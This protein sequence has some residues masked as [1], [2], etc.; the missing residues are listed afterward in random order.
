[1][2]TRNGI[3]ILSGQ[4]IIMFDNDLCKMLFMIIFI[5]E[6]KN[7]RRIKTKKMRAGGPTVI[8]K[9]QRCEFLLTKI[10]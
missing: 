6:K 8:R 10:N 9:G 2:I 5:I 1:M 7:R 4:K 3:S